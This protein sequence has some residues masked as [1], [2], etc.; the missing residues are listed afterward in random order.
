MTNGIVFVCLLKL[1]YFYDLKILEIITLLTCVMYI[2]HLLFFRYPKREIP[3]DE[4]LIVAPADGRV[5][6]LAEVKEDKYLQRLVI[7]VSIFMSVFDVHIIRIP[8]QA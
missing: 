1:L 4:N 8:S 5:I 2:F 3:A 7:M 6:D